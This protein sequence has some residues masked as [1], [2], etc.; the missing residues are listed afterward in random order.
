MAS[1][2]GVS[3]GPALSLLEGAAPLLRRSL[4]NP[5]ESHRWAGAW[6]KGLVDFMLFPA[7]GSL[8]AADIGVNGEGGYGERLALDARRFPQSGHPTMVVSPTG[9]RSVARQGI[10]IYHGVSRGA[11][12]KEYAR[13]AEDTGFESLWVTERYF[14]EETFSLLGFLASSTSRI[15]LGVG[16]VNPFTRHPA[17]LA[18]A[19][20]TMDRISG[21]RFI[22]GLGR[23]DWPVIEGKMG[24][25][26][27]DSRSTLREGVDIV[28]RL[29]AGETVTSEGG[30]FNINGVRLG[31]APVQARVPIY[32]AGIGP[33]ALR[34][35]GAVADGVLLNAYT[36]TRYVA[37]AVEDVRQAAAQQGRAA[38]D[39]DVACMMVVRPTD[40]APAM[41]AGLK[42]RVVR[43][44]D[45]P[46]VGEVLLEWSGFDPS[47]L[48]PLRR[49]VKL[50]GGESA[51]RLVTD[52]MVDA[53]Y[54]IGS[55]GRIRD[56][57]EEYRDAGVTLPILLPRLEAFAEVTHMFSS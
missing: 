36:S 23:S 35:A 22:L 48:G 21:G 14:H 38:G 25:P 39:V 52:E 42:E 55:E 50:D 26:H 13:Q 33:R 37:R 45:E 7:S 20:A 3:K 57:V 44:L 17:L 27:A 19:A 28:R 1:L 5:Q 47:I 12:L 56:R 53:F 34:M 24:I 49:S 9:G 11:E 32:L 29:L 54:L 15:R 51:L 16:V 43:L 46:H 31:V 8:T 4:G 10:V 2:V 30:R 18:M 40:D 6:D 41:R